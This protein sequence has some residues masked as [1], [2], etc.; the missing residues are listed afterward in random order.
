M[1]HLIVACPNIQVEKYP[2]DVLGPE[3]HE[4]SIARNPLEI[5]GP[6]VTITNR[7]GLGVD[8]DWDV[9]RK[10]LCS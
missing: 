4:V 10:H 1:G 7:P 8:V 3:Y 2:G 6:V 5:K 9:V